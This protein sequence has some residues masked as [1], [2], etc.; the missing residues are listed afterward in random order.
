MDVTIVTQLVSTVGF[1]IACCVALYWRMIKSDE[2][3]KSDNE[4][5]SEAINNNTL[6]ITKLVETLN[7]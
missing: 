1:P 5:F 6:A 4:K 2:Q 7:K 3:H